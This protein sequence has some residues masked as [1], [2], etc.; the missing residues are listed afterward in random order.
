MPENA[1]NG[2]LIGLVIDLSDPMK[3]G[4]V[5]V[6]F[7]TLEDQESSWCRVVTPMAGKD[8]GI[9]LRPEVDD[10]VLVVYEQG[11]P[12]RPYILGGLWSK[13]DPPPD[14]GPE[15]QN[16]LRFF[17]SRSGHIIKLDDT[18]GAEQIEIVDKDGSRK[19]VVDSGGSKIEISCG[20]GDVKIKAAAGNV[21]IEAMDITIKASKSLNLEAN[22]QLTI[23]GAMVNIN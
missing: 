13:K 10:E 11:D 15:R 19:I 23:K 14:G 2:I 22:A 17:K 21:S 5:K 9:F 8:R 6:S 4:R 1:E 12:R 16:N 18:S 20:T 7:P 3:L